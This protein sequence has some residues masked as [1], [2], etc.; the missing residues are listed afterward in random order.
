MDESAATTYVIAA[1]HKAS[2][3]IVCSCVLTVREF[4][5]HT[6]PRRL[7]SNSTGKVIR[8]KT[9]VAENKTIPAN[10]NVGKILIVNIPANKTQGMYCDEKLT[11]GTNAER[12][13][14]MLYA[15]AC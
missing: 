1:H 4:S 3:A 5:N 10:N 12:N 8:L 14:N 2:L 6:N 7:A 13:C 15:C 9:V 11:T